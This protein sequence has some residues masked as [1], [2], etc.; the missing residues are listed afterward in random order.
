MFGRTV[1]AVAEGMGGVAGLLLMKGTMNALGFSLGGVFRTLL[2]GLKAVSS[3]GVSGTWSL[4]TMGVKGAAAVAMMGVKVTASLAWVALRFAGWPALV[5]SALVGV[6]YAIDKFFNNGAL[7]KSILAGLDALKAQLNGRWDRSDTWKNAE[8]DPNKVLTNE[9]AAAALKAKST[10]VRDNMGRVIGIRDPGGQFRARDFTRELRQRGAFTPLEE[11][12]GTSDADM[13]FFGDPA[14]AAEVKSKSFRETW[15]PTV[16][17]L[18]RIGGNYLDRFGRTAKGLWDKGEE[19]VKQA[20]EQIA[21]NAERSPTNPKNAKA[22][23]DF[24]KENPLIPGFEKEGEEARAKGWEEYLKSYRSR[25]LP[26]TPARAALENL[27][28]YD[29]RSSKG[30]GY[31]LDLFNPQK[32]NRDEEKKVQE[33]I[34]EAAQ[35]T[36]S[37]LEKNVLVPV[38]IGKK[39]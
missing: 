37:A 7:T 27:G 12:A 29:A 14:R 28:D 10:Y 6:G 31:I 13:R 39:S 2:S 36:A 18:N 8:D 1:G 32:E 26:E 33:D 3:L 30:L 15:A 35:K 38:R 16:R 11:M 9:K 5:T 23:R 24:V 19:F 34:R 20:R 25:A 21:T 22:W 17:N 4:V